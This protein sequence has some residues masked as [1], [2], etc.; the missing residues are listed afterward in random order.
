VVGL[1]TVGALFWH[2]SFDQSVWLSRGDPFGQDAGYDALSDRVLAAAHDNGAT[3]IATT[4]YRTYAELLWHIGREI[5]VVQVN[6]RVRFL[7]FVPI[8]PELLRGPALYV[9]LAAPPPLLDGIES[10]TLS[11]VTTTWRD[12][13]MQDFSIALLKDFVP[14]LVPEPGSPAY[15]WSN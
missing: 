11:P 10:E 13:P 2:A 6:E 7:D 15:A 8:D 4:E 14:E 1:P 3:W 5:P 9:H 12:V